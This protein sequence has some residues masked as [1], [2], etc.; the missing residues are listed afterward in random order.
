MTVSMLA[1]LHVASYRALRT[2]SDPLITGRYLLPLV[3]IFGLT[4]AFV[5]SSLRPRLSAAL[6]TLV[7]AG[8]LA[9]NL[10]GIML[11][12]TRFYG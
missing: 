11:T 5:V 4:V 1:L 8:L 6:G 3:T 10:G 12:L 2:G 9:L 7:L